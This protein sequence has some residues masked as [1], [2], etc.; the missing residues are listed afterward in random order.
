ML[1]VDYILLP[2]EYAAGGHQTDR[3][4]WSDHYPVTTKIY[5]DKQ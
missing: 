2:L 5:F 4:P 1:R 3:I